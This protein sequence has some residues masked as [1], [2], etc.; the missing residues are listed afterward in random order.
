M[1]SRRG[2]LAGSVMVLAAPLA[3]EG[4]QA[5]KVCRVGT[6]VGGID[7][8]DLA[9]QARVHGAFDYVRK[10]VDFEYLE[11]SLDTAVRLRSL[12]A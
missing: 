11:R 9:R 3:G 12:T 7:S 5:G 8:I 1:I 4:R 6:M 2:F 10:P